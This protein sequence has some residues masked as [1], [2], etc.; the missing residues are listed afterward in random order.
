[1]E[2]STARNRADGGV[3]SRRVAAAGQECDSFHGHKEG[4]DR[5]RTRLDLTV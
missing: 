5:W 2:K 4:R 1:M 3:H